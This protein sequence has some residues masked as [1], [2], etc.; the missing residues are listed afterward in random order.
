MA[1]DYN[2]IK[3]ML[4]REKG[5]TETDVVKA[6][7]K[8][9]KAEVDGLTDMKRAKKDK[10]AQAKLAGPYEGDDYPYGL[11]IRLGEDEMEKLGIDLPTV[12]GT[13][14]IT[15]KAKVKSAEVRNDGSGEKKNC[16]LQIQKLKVG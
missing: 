8:K 5:A 6:Q 16:C 9:T 13:V 10:K 7:L 11:E 1:R 4:A 14:T 15:A 12:G 3:G 2:E